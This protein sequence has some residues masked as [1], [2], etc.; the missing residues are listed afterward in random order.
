MER[1]GAAAGEGGGRAVVGKGGVAAAGKPQGVE[2]L[3]W[4]VESLP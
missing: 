1:S 2:R 4:L 3:A